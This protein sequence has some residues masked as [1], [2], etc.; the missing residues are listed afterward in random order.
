VLFIDT[1]NAAFEPE[2][3]DAALKVLD[4]ARYNVHIARKP[5]GENGNLCCG[6]TFLAVGMVAEAKQ[7]AEEF[8]DALVPYAERGFPILGLEPS[9]LFTLKDEILSMQLGE[10]AQLVANHAMLIDTFLA[11]EASAGTLEAFKRQLKPADRP[12]LVHGHCHQK[13]FDEAAS[14]IK[15]LSLIPNANPTMIESSCCGMAGAFGYD[16]SHF[17]ISMAMAELSLLP[18]IR[19]ASDACIVADGTSCRHQIKDGS[20]RDAMHAIRTLAKQLRG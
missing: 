9:C 4:A 17:E 16:A 3:V 7:R 11:S 8:I 5:T 20:R 14:T 1:F 6:R 2:N 19:K 18:A 12:I 15:L 13:A 10:K